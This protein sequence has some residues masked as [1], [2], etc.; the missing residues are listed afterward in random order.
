MRR[1]ATVFGASGHTGRQVAAALRARGWDLILSGRDASRLEP[2]AAPWNAPV[3]A[4]TIDDPVALDRALE[5]AAVVINCAAPF[6]DTAPPLI[7]AALRAGIPY[8]DVA[9]ELE[10]IVDTIAEWDAPARRA[11]VTVAPALAF[12]GGVGDLLA[13]AAMAD[14]DAAD[15]IVIGYG[16]SGWVPTEGTLVSGA[17]SRERRNGLRPA[18]TG[19]RLTYRDT[20][21]ETTDWRFPPPIGPAHATGIV[22]ADTITIAHHL[23]A[24]EIRSYMTTR[25]LEDLSAQETR[26]R[27]AASDQHFAVEAIVRRGGEER[28]R[29]A[30]GGD[31]YA[32]TA[33]LV[34]TAADLVLS[35]RKSGI[36]V[37]GQFDGREQLLRAAALPA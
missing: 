24:P 3:R 11:G 37:A 36:V 9:A 33:P 6:R 13:T 23:K 29:A 5:G 35:E 10:A 12:Y 21:P 16:L 31:I 8:L 27:D 32:V 1:S 17:V 4:A 18:F 7:A 26:G 28:R 2:L 34:A 14:W 25:A 19:G 20:P 22:M 15:E 30:T